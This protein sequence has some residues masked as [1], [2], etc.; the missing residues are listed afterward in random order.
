MIREVNHE[1]EREENCDMEPVTRKMPI[2]IVEE[3]D[4]CMIRSH[5]D[6]IY[7]GSVG[8]KNK[9]GGLDCLQQ[10]G[11]WDMSAKGLIAG[12]ETTGAEKDRVTVTETE[13]V[14]KGDEYGQRPG[15]QHH[16]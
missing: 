14:E 13:D 5:D 6:D 7:F 1:L 4:S 16:Q 15:G 8:D 10:N 12:P 9:Q 11:L 3:E 2:T